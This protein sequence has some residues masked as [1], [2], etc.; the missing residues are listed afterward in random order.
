[1]KLTFHLQLVARLTFT[2]TS[3]IFSQF[4]WLSGNSCKLL[5]PCAWKEW[6]LFGEVICVTFFNT[7]VFYKAEE[8]CFYVSPHSCKSKFASK[9]LELKMCVVFQ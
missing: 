3:I 8:V 1:M 2:I 7:T 6:L 4:G 5:L 9:R